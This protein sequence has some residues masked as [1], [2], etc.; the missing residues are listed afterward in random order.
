MFHILLIQVWTSSANLPQ[1]IQFCDGPYTKVET[2]LSL[3]CTKVTPFVPP[4]TDEMLNEIGINTHI[5]PGLYILLDVAVSATPRRLAQ[6]YQPMLFITTYTLFNL[7]YYLCGGTVSGS[8]VYEE[9]YKESEY[10]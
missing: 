8:L 2:P 4:L 9:T 10:L 3:P 5:I 1:N 6:A 7:I